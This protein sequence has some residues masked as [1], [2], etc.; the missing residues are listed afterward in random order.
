MQLA[1][2]VLIA[3]PGIGD[4]RFERS[5]VLLCVHAP[6]AAMGVVVN[7]PRPNVT[8]PDV[9]DQLGITGAER[10]PAKPVLDGGPVH[11]DRGFVL[12]SADFGKSDATQPVAPGVCL[13]ATRDVLEALPDAAAPK[14]YVLALGYAGWGPGQLESEISANVW[15]VGDPRPDLIFGGEH[16][17]KWLAAMKALGVDPARLLEPGGTIN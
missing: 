6:D 9:L 3:M 15:L 2:K 14:D 12:H 11:P 7:K 5:V 1:G 8:L 10:V 17:A 4:P 16:D 13:T